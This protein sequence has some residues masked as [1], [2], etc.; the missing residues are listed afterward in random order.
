MKSIAPLYVNA[1]LLETN[2]SLKGV[3]VKGIDLN[4]PRGFNSDSDMIVGGAYVRQTAHGKI[5]RPHFSH[6]SQR[7]WRLDT[8]DR[9]SLYLEKMKMLNPGQFGFAASMKLDFWSTM[10]GSSSF[11]APSFKTCQTAAFKL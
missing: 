6:P 2:K 1:G 8:N 10:N 5:G 11:K 4:D 9:I 7:L 3:S